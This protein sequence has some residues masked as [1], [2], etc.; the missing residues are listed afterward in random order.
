MSFKFMSVEKKRPNAIKAQLIGT[1]E[2][3]ARARA[4]LKINTLRLYTALVT[5]DIRNNRQEKKT[6][7]WNVN[8]IIKVCPI[9]EKIRKC[10]AVRDSFPFVF[11]EWWMNCVLIE[12]KYR[13]RCR[14]SNGL[15][16]MV[17]AFT[18]RLRVASASGAH[19]GI[20]LALKCSTNWENC[21]NSQFRF[22][23]CCGAL[24]ICVPC[25]TYLII[26]G[27]QATAAASLCVSGI[28]TICYLRKSYA[29]NGLLL[30]LQIAP[31]P[32]LDTASRQMAKLKKQQKK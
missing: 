21:K 28:Y 27:Q 6:N 4:P 26:A 9:N 7:M 25:S 15:D 3:C 23:V 20:A 8:R 5:P 17:K 13:H 14:T 16:A 29:I 18:H 1:W 22:M 31:A 19:T 30:Y 2:E 11:C 10:L 12:K 32:A 24:T